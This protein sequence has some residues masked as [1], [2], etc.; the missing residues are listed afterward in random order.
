MSQ[1]WLET[2]RGSTTDVVATS[3]DMQQV[4]TAAEFGKV[5][6]SQVWSWAWWFGI[7]LGWIPN[8]DEDKVGGLRKSVHNNYFM[9]LSG[10]LFLLCFLNC[11]RRR[12]RLFLPVSRHIQG[13]VTSGL[14][15]M[16]AVVDNV[17]SFWMASY[18]KVQLDI[19]G[20]ILIHNHD[21]A[22]SWSEL[23]WAKSLSRSSRNWT[24]NSSSSLGGIL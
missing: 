7:S 10:L 3:T 22:L 20:I 24:F 8:L 16:G 18:S 13:W 17:F 9:T 4:H 14:A 12:L 19:V 5:R 2:H 1:I 15:K 23:G 11:P 6:C 21:W